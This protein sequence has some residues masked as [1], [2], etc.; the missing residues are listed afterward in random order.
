[1]LAA[2]VHSLTPRRPSKMM[3]HSR[4]AITQHLY[5][6]VPAQMQRQAAS[7]LDVLLSAG[8]DGDQNGVAGGSRSSGSAPSA[9]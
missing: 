1:M 5:T 9:S 6:H 3:G 7:A 4:T 8:D 2:F